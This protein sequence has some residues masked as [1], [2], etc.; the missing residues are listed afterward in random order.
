[1]LL[2]S[3]N[4]TPSSIVGLKGFP[5]EETQW[6][7]EYIL[8]IYVLDLTFMTQNPNLEIEEEI[9]RHKKHYLIKSIWWFLDPVAKNLIS[10]LLTLALI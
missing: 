10:I 7:Y 3:Y 1:M 9:E 5:N 2:E 4:R 8:T 6:I